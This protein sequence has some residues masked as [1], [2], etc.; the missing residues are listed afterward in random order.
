MPERNPDTQPSPRGFIVA[1]SASGSGKTIATCGIISAFRRQGLQVRAAK[2][3]PDYI[4]PAFL[5]AAS[6]HPAI[7]LDPWAMT[8]S[9]INQRLA[10]HG[11]DTDLVVV[12]GVMGLFDGAQDGKGSTAHLA[13][14]TGLPV[15]LIV[16]ASGTAQSVAAIAEGFARRARRHEISLSGVIA[17]QIASPRH[18]ELVREGFCDIPAPLFGLMPRNARLA[19][20]S[21][22]LGLVQA[23]E[24]NTIGKIMNEAGRLAAANIDIKRLLDCA[25]PPAGRPGDDQPRH[26][27]TPPGQ[28]IAIAN[29]QAFAFT[30][31]HWLDDFRHGGAEI[32][33][34]SPLAD[35]P[36]DPA[37]DAI[38]LPGGYPELHA[39]TLAAATGF[40]DAL[41]GAASLNVPIYG[42]CGGYMALGEGLIDASGNRHAM[43]GLLPLV[44]DFSKPKLHLGYRQLVA[45]DGFFW[46]GQLRA[47]E[48]HYATVHR[49]GEADRL[50]SASD[51]SNRD[52]GKIGLRRGSVAGSFAHIIDRHAGN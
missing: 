22:H 31:A 41:A 17:T 28:R 34:F 21:R 42:E 32:T 1:G 49:E 12:E 3:G 43:A 36:P 37:A 52:L 51:A 10:D 40:K 20:K 46:P 48:F 9:A 29:D 33:F 4:D 47:H 18:G 2:S 14:I 50:F 27:L 16:N 8:G 15:V 30:Y 38:L 24:H 45:D 25:G 44:T 19:L 5:S 6:G 11:E 23:R 13:R 7:N 35:E 39:E 26:R